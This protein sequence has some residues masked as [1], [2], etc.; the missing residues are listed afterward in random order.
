MTTT[1]G[2]ADVLLVSMETVSR[3]KSPSSDWWVLERV[4]R[5]AGAGLTMLTMLAVRNQAMLAGFQTRGLEHSSVN[6]VNTD[7][8]L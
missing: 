8:L 6:D 4:Q 7:Y 5:G 2:H 3:Q 1:S